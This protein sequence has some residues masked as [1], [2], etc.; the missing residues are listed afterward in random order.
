MLD[1]DSDVHYEFANYGFT[2]FEVGLSR[3]RK[4]GNR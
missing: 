4:G 3:R 1:N 2:A